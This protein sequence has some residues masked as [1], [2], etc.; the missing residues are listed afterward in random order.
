[1][2]KNLLI[3]VLIILS[4]KSFSQCDSAFFRQAATSIYDV[5]LITDKII[6][7]VGYNGYIIKSADGGNS[8]RNIP[9]NYGNNTLKTVQFANDSTGY[10]TGAGGIMKTE[11]Q[12]E[13][14]FSLQFPIDP[15]FGSTYY[16]MHFF[17]KD[18]GIFVGSG[19]HLLSTTNGG[20]SFKDTAIGSNAFFSIDFIDDST[21]LIAG[22]AIYK[23]TNSGK[24]WRKIDI[25]NLMIDPTSSIRK[26]RFVTPS[27]AIAA[28][29]NNTFATS[30]D[31][32]ET[33]A[34][35]TPNYNVSGISDFFF[36]D[37]TNGIALGNS[38]N[39]SLILH[40]SDGGRTFS[41]D[42][43]DPQGG[44]LFSLNSDPRGKQVMAVGGSRI[45]AAS[46]GR[47]I[48][49][50]L[51]KGNTW[52]IQSNNPELNYSYTQFLNDSTGFIAGVDDYFYKTTDYGE[53]WKRLGRAVTTLA[54]T[55]RP[56]YFSDSLHGY[57][58]IGNV[59]CL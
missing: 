17:N 11:D 35:G 44:S 45:N 14:W 58:V 56:F 49:T 22:D 2:K 34:P 21:G 6:V 50:T 38:S 51:D 32:G 5:S 24:T 1:M 7:G 54:N 16:D 26:I 23:T 47:Y 31:G 27:F 37:S 20:R 48:I 19:G 46:N 15:Y 55:P 36:F 29:N 28:A 10:V 30:S 9:N 4:V 18:T 25:A 39:G 59:C 42:F 43:N 12:G 33:W 41:I 8:W 53:S 3:C 52:S 57:A 40:T 13:S